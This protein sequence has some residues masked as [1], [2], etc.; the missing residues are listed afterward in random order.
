[1]DATWWGVAIGVALLTVFFAVA[2][3]AGWRGPLPPDV[4]P[5]VV[6]AGYLILLVAIVLGGYF[7]E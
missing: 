2:V 5:W 6:M 1:M 7:F 3:S 4:S